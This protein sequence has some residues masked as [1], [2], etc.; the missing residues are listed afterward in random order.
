MA[1]AKIVEDAHGSLRLRAQ[2]HHRDGVVATL[3]KLGT[4]SRGIGH[5]RAPSRTDQSEMFFNARSSNPNDATTRRF[6]A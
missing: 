3:G 5:E 1:L 2:V 4:V 6:P